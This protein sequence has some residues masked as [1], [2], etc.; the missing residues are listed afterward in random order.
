[1][2][3]I[4]SSLLIKIDWKSLLI[5]AFGPLEITPEFQYLGIYY[6]DSAS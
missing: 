2:I 4:D 5:E 6:L 3:D 1:M